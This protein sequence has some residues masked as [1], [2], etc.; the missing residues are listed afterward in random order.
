M[1][2]VKLCIY[3]HSKTYDILIDMVHSIKKSG[4]CFGDKK[5]SQSLLIEKAIISYFSHEEYLKSILSECN[6]I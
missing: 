6:D 2:K 1:K 5:I 4:D 3:M